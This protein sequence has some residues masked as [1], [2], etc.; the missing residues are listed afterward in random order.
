MKKLSHLVSAV[1]A[2]HTRIPEW[3]VRLFSCWSD[4]VGDLSKNMYIKKIEKNILYV[5]VFDPRWVY[6]LYLLHNTLLHSISTYLKEEYIVSID[7]SIAPRSY[8]KDQKSTSQVYTS[9][10]QK[11]KLVNN[12]PNTLDLAHESMLQKIT[13]KD[14]R[15][16]LKHLFF[17]CK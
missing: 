4:I 12:V 16:T 17:Y 8:N 6:E 11:K 3:H 14:L 2:N 5:S 1:F 9:K 7:F 13:D 15:Q 10:I